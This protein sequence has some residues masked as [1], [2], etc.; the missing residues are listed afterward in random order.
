MKRLFVL[1]LL[2]LFFFQLQAQNFDWAKE[3]GLFAYDYGYGISTDIVGNVYISGKYEMNA[4]FSDSILTAYGNHDIYVAKYSS[5]GALIWTRTAG[6]VYGD[7]AHALACD[8]LNYVYVAGEIEGFETPI[9]FEGSAI[10][11]TSSG[12]NDVF[13]AKYDLNGNLLWANQAGGYYGDEALGIT[14]DY[15]GNVYVCGFFTDTATFSG[16]TI[17]GNGNRDIFIAKYDM[18]GNFLWVNQAGSAGRDE[19]KAIKCDAAGNVYIAGM[20]K[21]SAIFGSS[22]LLSPLGYFNSFLA[23]Y[24]SDGSLIWVKDSGGDYDD[25][26]WALT[27]DDADK[28]YITGEF[29]A[30]AYFDT[31]QLITTGQ[32]NIFVACYNN[33]GNIEW[34]SSAGGPLIDRA[35]GIGCDGTNIYITGQFSM[36]ANFGAYTVTG[37]DSAEIFMAKI[38]NSGGFEWVT[39]IGGS[40]DVTE[41]LGYEAGNGICAEASGNVYATGTL[42]NGGVFGSTTLFPYS[43]T[44]I[45]LAKIS[46]GPDITAPLAPIYNPLDNAFDVPNNSNLVLTFNE[47][48]QK[49]TGN[50]IIKEDGF[51]TQTVDVTGANVIVSGNIVTIDPDNFTLESSVN[52]EMASGVFKDL[53]NNNYVGI[54]DELMWNFSISTTTSVNNYSLKKNFNLYPNPTSNNFTINSNLPEAQKIE[55]TITNC[56]GQVV[57]KKKYNYSSQLIIDLSVKQKGIYFI[58]IKTDDQASFREKIFYQ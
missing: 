21:D 37:I 45:F 43:R 13:L 58:E 23:K 52:V 6:G 19:A 30:S 29:N 54:G 57:D 38:N 9:N 33:S 15:A 49:G 5:T 47:V 12:L 18:N 46:Q 35:R 40:P 24:A 41:L 48:V 11:L 4:N 34:A 17:Y 56:I 16:T 2:N 31:I 53:A 51:V 28:I 32:A 22:I 1:I 20:Y 3:E 25:L 50:I 14:Y 55:I 7:Y 10:T 8:K 39:S 36:S 27:I 26:A 44:D 42:I